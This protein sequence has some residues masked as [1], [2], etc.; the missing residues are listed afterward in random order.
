MLLHKLRCSLFSIFFC[1][2]FIGSFSYFIEDIRF[3]RTPLVSSSM[4]FALLGF[5]LNSKSFSKNPSNIALFTFAS[6]SIIFYVAYAHITYEIDF[7]STIALGSFW[8]LFFYTQSL[9]KDE[10]YVNSFL[11]SLTLITSLFILL[12]LQLGIL[13]AINPNAIGILAVAVLLLSSYSHLIKRINFWAWIIISFSSLYISIYH[14]SRVSFVI[15]LAISLL[16]SSHYLNKKYFFY[17][18]IIGLISALSFYYLTSDYMND[19]TLKN[20][21]TSG[22]GDITNGRMHV[23]EVAIQNL[24]WFGH[25]PIQIDAFL[26]YGI[27]NSYLA[28]ILK[29]GLFQ[30]YIIIFLLLIFFMKNFFRLF[31][32]IRIVA[33]I[34][35]FLLIG[36]FEE[37]LGSHIFL[38]LLLAFAIVRLRVKVF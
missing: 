13:S 12:L 37:I 36:M 9:Q 29:F 27:H 26:P 28:F 11:I 19:L 8:L 33:F 38:F 31:K 24:N 30:F 21:S 32:N 6:I 3:L 15:V 2:F 25:H 7:N 34:I 20:S 5:I 16:Y 22:A 1:L 14:Q 18:A 35:P 10:L 17:Y 4:I 23:W